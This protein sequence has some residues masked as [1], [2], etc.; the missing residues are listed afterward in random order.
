M[1]HQA[2]IRLATL[3]PLL[4]LLLPTSVAQLPVPFLTIFML[5]F[6]LFTGP[7]GLAAILSC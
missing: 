6:R 5:T 4:P 1:D 3:T 7:A 2:P